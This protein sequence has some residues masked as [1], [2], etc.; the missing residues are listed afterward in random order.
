MNKKLGLAVAGAVMAF[1][2][3]AANAA[4]TIPAGDW[5][6]DI[7]GNVNAY[8]THTKFSGDLKTAGTEDVANTVQTG[9]LPSA[10]GIGG[11]TRQNDL[12]IA[13]QF[14]FFTGVDSGNGQS[15]GNNSLN[16]RQAYLT[17]GDKSW[18]T[19]KAGRDLGIF[20]SDAILSDM[21]LLGVGI[22]AGSGGSSTL[23][24]I[25]SG[26]MYADW[27]GQISYIS[28]NWNGFSF[29]VGAREPWSNGS[30]NTDI[31]N[32]MGYEG[33]VSYEWTG[34]Y[35][36]KVWLGAITQKHSTDTGSVDSYTSRGWDLGGKVNLAG[37]GLVGY[38][39]DG[40]GLSG[41]TAAS[42]STAA[43]GLLFLA[44]QKS[45]DKGGYVQ[46]TYALPG[47]GTKL[48]LSYGVSKSEAAASNVEFENKSWIVGAYHPLTKSLNLVA[49]YTDNKL[50]NI[51]Y[52]AGQDGKAKT[53]S[54][55]AILFF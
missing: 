44:G 4:I 13:F 36:G 23:G 6:I 33:K 38:Y 29:A 50:E 30:S 39:Y 2:A 25:G 7:G 55:G 52:S 1:G 20:G 49:E 54:L 18:G 51:G 22:G 47:V 27:V 15:G 24:R 32:D 46:A 12:D 17:F 19:I 3:S 16:I 45:D 5:T 14:T 21:T 10:L 31:R 42:L 11:K 28:P 43:N 53:V 40:K 48:G 37:V 34:D 41:S 9:L 35:A 26:Y 8:Y